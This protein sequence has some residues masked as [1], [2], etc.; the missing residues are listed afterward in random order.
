[1]YKKTSLFLILIAI[2]SIAF[3]FSGAEYL[4]QALPGGLPFGNALTAI[5]LI[6][7]AAAAVGL[8]QAG[9][10]LRRISWSALV[11]AVAWLPVSIGLA[12]NL[13]LNFSGTRGSLW[14]GLSLAT[15][16]VVLFSLGW[17]LVRWVVA[18]CS[19]SNSTTAI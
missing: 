18:L 4:Q 3:L 12:G 5:G 13:A 1:M 6:S 10:V 15:V 7:A 11:A 14:I 17:A 9:T 19:R 16:V 8:G 2:A